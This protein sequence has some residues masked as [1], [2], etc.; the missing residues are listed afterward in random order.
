[1]SSNKSGFQNEDD[2]IFY[3][4]MRQF[5]DLNENMK[6]FLHFIYHDIKDND[7][8]MARAGIPRQKPD[9]EITVN[10]VSKNISVKKGTGNSVHQEGVWS[11]MA[12]LKSIGVNQNVIDE[13][14]RYHWSDG[15]NDGNGSI[16]VSSSEYKASHKKQI[17]RIN[18]EL[19]KPKFLTA[20]TNRI[21]FQGNNAAFKMAEYIYHGNI[22]QGHWASA[23]EIVNYANLHSFSVNSVHFG[24]LTYQI[25]NSC[26]NHNP[27]TEARRSVMQSKWGTISRDLSTIECERRRH[28]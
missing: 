9:L 28:E 8:V 6:N 10:N 18:D 11:F 7:I 23:N 13:L 17:K 21:L 20:I 14:L 19:N 5:R 12:F 25:W 2:I 22:T 15:S 26:L 1:M 24:P 27:N 3:L 16:R 4:N